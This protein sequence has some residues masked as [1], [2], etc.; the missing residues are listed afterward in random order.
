ME[1][2]LGAFVNEL[3]DLPGEVGV[4]LDDYHVI[5]SASV[6]RIVSFM[7]ERPTAH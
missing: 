7:L 4:V 6:H 3:A 1:A 5:D 2:V